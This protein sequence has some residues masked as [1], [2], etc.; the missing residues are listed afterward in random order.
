[1]KVWGA[2]HA[3]KESAEDAYHSSSTHHKT[4]S[5]MW[6]RYARR[7]MLVEAP[8]PK[9][10]A[11]ELH[12]GHHPYSGNYLRQCNRPSKLSEANYRL[13]RHLAAWAAQIT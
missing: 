13:M 9:V 7:D 2:V 3:D 10:T 1:M 11:T 8:K 4:S 12:A 6:L 5:D